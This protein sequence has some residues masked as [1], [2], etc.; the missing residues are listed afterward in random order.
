MRGLPWCELPASTVRARSRCPLSPGRA[1]GVFHC[2]GIDAS[3]VRLDVGNH[4]HLAMW[5]PGVVLSCPYATCVTNMR[6]EVSPSWLLP[7]LTHAQ[8]HFLLPPWTLHHHSCRG[9]LLFHLSVPLPPPSLFLATTPLWLL[10][11]FGQQTVDLSLQR[12]P[13]LVHQCP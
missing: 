13:N 5:L 9:L 2:A 1:R 7:P 8:R 12:F 10:P 6:V 11:Y 3:L 4:P